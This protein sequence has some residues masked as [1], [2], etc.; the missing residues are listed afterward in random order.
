MQKTL[1]LLFICSFRIFAEPY[2]GKIKQM[3]GTPTL[4]IDNKPV[5]ASGV[6]LNTE[7][8]SVKNFIFQKENSVFQE[9]SETR[10]P[11]FFLGTTAG[12]RGIDT[13]NYNYIDRIIERLLKDDPHAYIIPSIFLG[14]ISW[15]SN[16]FPEERYR[17]IENGE[18]K[19]IA[20]H[21]S[22]WS[23]RFY[24]E[25]KKALSHFIK[26]LESKGYADRILGFQIN[27]GKTSEWNWW[28]RQYHPDMNPQAI[29]AWQNFLKNKYKTIEQ[30]NL[31]HKTTWKNFNEVIPQLK[32]F[33]YH[34]QN[35]YFC[36]PD[37]AMEKRDYNKFINA[38]MVE[39]KRDLCGY[40]KKITKNRAVTGLYN[41]C[42]EP[43]LDGAP[44]IDFTVSS[45]FY[46]DRSINGI[47]ISQ[48]LELEHLR[49]IGVLYFHDAD[50]RTYLWPDGTYGVAQNVYESVM[51][52]RREFGAMF[53]MGAGNTWFSLNAY[54]NVYSNPEIMRSIAQTEALANAAISDMNYDLSSNAQIAVVFDREKLSA[55][56][57]N[58]CTYSNYGRLGA[59]V[60]FFPSHRL[61][62]ISKQ[63]KVVVFLATPKLHLEQ[64]DNL[65]KDNR[66]LLFLY[67][68]GMLSANG[69]RVENAERATH[70][71]LKRLPGIDKEIIID[72]KKI[73]ELGKMN[74]PDSAFRLTVIPQNGDQIL[75][76]AAID[77]EVLFARHEHK[78]WTGIYYHN[79]QMHI[80]ILR[81]IIQDAGVTIRDQTQECFFYSN[82]HFEVI[83]AN[84]NGQDK[85]LHVDPG[86]AMLDI[87][88][89]KLIPV[90]NNTAILSNLRPYE[91]KILLMDTP[92]KIAQYR[93]F[94][95]EELKKRTISPR[96]NPT[97][98]ILLND[99]NKQ[100]H[101]MCGRKRILTLQVYTNKDIKNA[102]LYTT[103]PT[104]WKCPPIKLGDMKQYE[105]KIVKLI[106]EPQTAN[107]VDDATINIRTDNE[108][109]PA[110]EQI[111][112]ISRNY[113]YLS[114]LPPVSGS[115]GW[116]TIGRDSS[117]NKKQLRIGGKSYSKGYGV[118]AKSKMTFD[119][120]KKWEFLSGIVGID[121]NQ[122]HGSKGMASASFHIFGDGIELFSTDTLYGGGKTQPFNI[123]V[124]GIQKLEL[125]VDDGGDGTSRDHAD[126]CD[127]KLFPPQ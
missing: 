43:E 26:H 101:G 9:F 83:C 102:K 51:M 28:E 55:L 74:A 38:R 34:F 8:G 109:I 125:I 18:K 60:D 23:Q 81:K 85:I 69:L 58:Y 78:D 75:G 11:V 118:H 53:T 27:N 67:G 94:Y 107:R 40:V 70:F 2:P 3:N 106:L 120:N 80:D 110:T 116:G 112:F 17:Y 65:K 121:N 41:Y 29:S 57:G 108:I 42:T 105:V 62:L 21:S 111:K 12:W 36:N 82:K 31:R 56:W 122:I 114:D 104:D 113:L 30:L 79:Y 33:R 87:F 91:T 15:F 13:Y 6:R 37:S 14:K 25:S 93:K 47:S 68:T 7:W 45:T 61:D 90:T 5:Y 48:M 46:L 19:E 22:L 95:Q 63:Y 10:T 97:R 35:G 59:A 127:L 16:N 64:L 72:N 89:D 96:K 49:R 124:T 39:L 86:Y 99:S 77:N 103:L 119:L 84:Q 88:S 76:R 117:C 24:K 73:T 100:I 66:T 1:L 98:C 92:Q 52:M 123:S 115:T 54:A 126:W 4:F 44:E 71:K 20:Y 32:T 50:M